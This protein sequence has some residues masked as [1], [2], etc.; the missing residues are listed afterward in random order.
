MRISE[1]LHKARMTEKTEERFI[2]HEERPAFHLTP[3]IGWMNDPNGFSWY[4]GEYHLFYQYYPYDTAWGPMHW[5]HA[6]S[7]DLMH[8]EN[9][10]CAL[11]PDS[12]PDRE[13]GCFSGG[14]VELPDGRHLLMYTGCRREKHLD[15]TV[16]D[17]QTQNLAVGDGMDYQKYEGNPVLTELDIP[18]G[19]S[20]IDFRDP[21]IWREKD[22]SWRC[23]VA[24]RAE[25]Q[26]GQLLLFTSADAFHWSYKS[27]LSVNHGRFGKMWECPD[28]FEMDGCSVILISPQDMEP[29][30]A[31]FHAGNNVLCMIGSFSEEDGR[32]KEQYVQP[33]DDGIDFYATQTVLAPDGRR[34]LLGWMQ[35]WDTVPYRKENTRWFGQVTIPR[36]LTIRDGHLY[37]NPVREVE[38]YRGD[39]IEKDRI[40]VDDD[41]SL[42]CPELA[43]RTLDLTLKIRAAEDCRRVALR[44]AEGGKHYCEVLY[45]PE[46]GT[47]T[48]DRSH[49]GVSRDVLHSRTVRLKTIGKELKLRL[50]LDRYSAEIFVNDGESAMTMT[51]Y[52]DLAERGISVH[53]NGTAE[54]D[55]TGYRIEIGETGR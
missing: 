32:F 24:N 51:Y 7:K 55:L 45:R 3:R 25:D 42:V 41:H 49:S 29:D 11:A 52:S 6:V 28:Y 9:R 33:V 15:G 31:G 20:R 38:Q 19:A 47:L 5:G 53:A 46:E 34:I 43:G 23:V 35:S 10:P 36:E 37:Q 21:K 14:A 40:Q 50:I 22:G 1:E 8:W 16:C 2:A 30:D 4:K 17:V 26:T 48:I 12:F 44:F 13:G 27:A 54:I 39:K 18:A